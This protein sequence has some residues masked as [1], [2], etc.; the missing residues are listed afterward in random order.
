MSAL[1]AFILA[2]P[3][4]L[5]GEGWRGGPRRDASEQTLAE[6][7]FLVCRLATPT[8]DPS[9]QGGGE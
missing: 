4:G 6:I 8:L 3:S 5:V 2:A 9:P 7:G 1:V